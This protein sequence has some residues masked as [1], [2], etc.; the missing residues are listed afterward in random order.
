[1]LLAIAAVI[2]LLLFSAIA[3]GQ[4]YMSRKAD[5]RERAVADAR[6][7]SEA[8]DREL[9]ASLDDAR[10]LADTPALDGDDGAAIFAETARRQAA[11]R[12]LWLTV[13]LSDAQGRRLVNVKSPKDLGPPVEPASVQEVLRKREAVI[14]NLAAG[15]HRLGLPVRAPV[16]RDGKVKY[17]V[18][19]VVDP[20]QIHDSLIASRLPPGWLAAAV[21]RGGRIVASTRR[22]LR[23]SGA[24]ASPR[25]IA[26]RATAQGG[27][28]EGLNIDNEKTIVAFW[29]SPAYGWS[30]HVGAPLDQ[31][32][33]PLRRSLA[34]TV[35]G[36]LLALLLTAAFVLLLL[37][38]SELRRREAASFEQAQR[39]EALGRL[40][41]GVAH[42]FN[43][44]LMIIQGNAD[45]LR[46]RIKEPA[47][48]RPLEAIRIATDRAAKLTRELLVFAR[49]GRGERARLD[50]NAVL[51]NFLGSLQ[52]AAG[53]KN[54]VTLELDPADP[55]VETDRVQLEMALLNLTVNARDAMAAGGAIVMATHGDGASVTLAVRDTGP[56][57]AP[58]DLGRVFDPFFTTKAASGGTGLG[59]TQVY[60][61]ARQSGGSVR[62]DNR[63]GTGAA[64]ILTLPQAGAAEPEPAAEPE[65]QS[66]AG[67]RILL[68]DDNAE[69]RR[70]AAVD[71]RERGA[72]VIEAAS[73]AEGVGRLE[74]QAF[75]AV[76]SDIVMPGAID[77][78][79]LAAEAARRWPELPVLLV[80]GYSAQADEA[81]AR[82]LSVLPKPYDLSALAGQLA[83][84]Q[85][86]PSSDST[87]DVG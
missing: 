80:S 19:I 85:A 20:D 23:V 64:V 71:L 6:R 35:A 24:L 56:G 79:A 10:D 5:I 15:P 70:L 13:I 78:L 72:E 74:Q 49:G 7:V 52:E 59:L 4:A 32:E 60:S 75:D 76:V 17:I 26:A 33:A 44:L 16:L 38:E 51:R 55:A 53:P 1:M 46:R 77:G 12:P 30:V 34:L 67:R 37:R 54:T 40:T 58:E 81:R 86:R 31:L 62:I 84:M 87:L 66:I 82:G 83:R 9:A 42:D 69:V 18:S 3:S 73:G 50:V 11:H 2:P 41:G 8:V 43:N 47:A 22:D 25:A 28:Y 14:G 36:L 27:I 21:D 45:I 63:P 39:L 29:T 57:F 61:L 65:A 48:G 68:V